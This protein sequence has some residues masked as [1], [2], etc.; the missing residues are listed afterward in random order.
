M[1]MSKSHSR[2]SQHL[3]PD[4]PVPAPPPFEAPAPPPAEELK[5]ESSW[6]P[7]LQIALTVWL[8]GFI[9]LLAWMVIDL[10][11]GLWRR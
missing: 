1:V 6:R 10:L 11:M 3:Q 7:G 2:R 8:A 5:E 9:G 4:R